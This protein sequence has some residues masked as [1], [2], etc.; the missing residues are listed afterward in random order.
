MWTTVG[1]RQLAQ[2]LGC[3][4]CTWKCTSQLFKED[5]LPLSPM[6]WSISASFSEVLLDKCLHATAFV[7]ENNDPNTPD[8]LILMFNTKEKVTPFISYHFFKSPVLELIKQVL[9]DQMVL[10]AQDPQHI[11]H[12]GFKPR[13]SGSSPS[14]FVEG[15]ESRKDGVLAGV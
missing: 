11:Q 2:V 4:F 9:R 1:L 13:F 7:L 6:D 3:I 10:R 5:H 12:L 14:L 15:Q 8:W